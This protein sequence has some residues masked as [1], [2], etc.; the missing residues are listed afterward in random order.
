MKRMRILLLVALVGLAPLWAVAQSPAKPAKSVE[1]DETLQIRLSGVKLSFIVQYI[2]IRT[3]KHVI[4][5]ERFPGESPVDVVSGERVD[6]TAD[7]AMSIFAAVLRNAGYAMKETEDSIEIVL[8]AKPGVVPVVDEVPTTGLA[9]QTLATFIVDVNHVDVTEISGVL[10]KMKSKAG[11]IQASTT[12]NRLVITEYAP[13]LSAMLDI[14]RRLDRKPEDSGFDVYKVK[15]LSP[16]SLMRLAN[17]YIKSLKEA[18]G[19]VEKS[20]LETLKVEANDPA[21]SIIIY[22]RTDDIERV[23][24]HLLRFDVKPTEAAKQYHVYA[25]LNRDASELRGVLVEL[26]KSAA[27]GKDGA[28]A[29]TPV[30]I[31]ADGVNNEL[32]FTT[33]LARYEEIRPLVERLDRVVAQVVIE[34][35]LVELSLEKMLDIGLELSSLDTPGSSPRGFGATTY[36]LSTVTNEGRVPVLP[37]MGGFTGGIFKDS[38]FQIAALIRLAAQDNDVSLLIAPS[39]MTRDNKEASIAI[40]ESRE[41]IEREV[42]AEGNTTLI[43][44]GGSNDAKV[45]LKITPHIN[46]EGTVRLEITTIIQQFLPSSEV[47]GVPLINK[48]TRQAITEVMVSDGDTIVIG[49]LTSTVEVE[50]VSGVPLLRNIPGLGFLFRRTEHT[51]QQRNLCVF[52]TPHIFRNSEELLEEA[53][54]KRESLKKLR[55]DKPRGKRD[56]EQDETFDKLTGAKP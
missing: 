37:A 38:A 47:E 48:T 32:I 50:T 45:E 15:N 1:A 56:P 34:S 39:I 18:A 24:A 30:I 6:I 10:E 35:A 25:V 20:R 27:S 36:G 23:K 54:E 49:G 17:S 22:G 51:K 40:T 4:L 12:S 8:E 42:S 31:T 43:S 2:S 13:V 7:E 19:P 5:P 29:T 33:S 46:E 26:L 16:Q 41:T 52:I 28:L 11:S 53:K 44:S 14:I 55:S 9:A 3:G 21:N